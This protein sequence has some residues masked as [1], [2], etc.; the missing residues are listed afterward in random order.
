MGHPS[1]AWA[2]MRGGKKMSAIKFVPKGWGY[3]KWIVNNE[4][5]CGSNAKE[6]VMY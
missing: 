3:E 2:I 5:Y 4:K 6:F 1:R